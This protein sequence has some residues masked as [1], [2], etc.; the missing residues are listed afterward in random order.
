MSRMKKP[1]HADAL[2]A[3][4]QTLR[5]NAERWARMG[6][7]Q[8]IGYLE[9]C[10]AGTVKVAE[11]QIRAAAAAKGLPLDSPLVGEEWFAGPVVQARTLRLLLD[12]L[13]SVAA[14]GTVKLPK[15]STHPHNGQTVVQVFPTSTIDKLTFAGFTA[16]VWMAPGV[17]PDD[18]RDH[19]AAFYREPDPKPAVA[20]VLGAGNV[21]SIGPLDVIQKLFQ[22]GQVVMLKF[23][24]V[25]DYLGPFVE[26]AFAG[27]IRDGFLRTCYGGADVGAYL[28]DHAEV[29]EIHVTGS[30]KT[31]DVIVFGPGKAGE[32]R[33]KAGTPKNPRRVTSELGNVSPVIIVPGPWN[34]ADI[35]FHA[36]NV[37]TQLA[38]NGG[39]NCNAAKV[40]ITQEGWPLEQRFMDTLREVLAGIPQ[41]KAYYP[42][43]EDRY[44]AFVGAH[45]QSE[46]IGP[47]REGVLP[48]TLI[49]E[50][51]ADAEGEMC[52][53]TEAFCGVLAQTRLP[54]VDAR[55]FLKA[56]V[57]FCNDTLWG[58]LNACLIVHPDTASALGADLE[59]AI[60][61]LRYGTVALNHWPALAYGLGSTPWGAWPG[62]TPEDIQSGVGHVHNGY[63]IDDPQKTII[64]GPFRV[65]PKPPWFV[66]NKAT[67]KV[68][69]AMLPMELKPSLLKL[70]KV[71]FAALRG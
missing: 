3:D 55:A 45:A 43:A 12:S 17:A 11:R 50:V 44:R 27:L 35:R 52:F 42:G 28:T 24:P 48:W 1:E 57:D 34:A 30:D 58:T 59:Q 51:P 37:A 22:E 54:G 71:V 29:D 7:Q 32:K 8:R 9:A 40:L 31:H 38:N 6:I 69:R 20:L 41:R 63:L 61:D 18:M 13:R 70:P 2:D 26:E 21:A 23:N 49:P 67:D 36:E 4:L 5:A 33:K 53:G 14:S 56:A 46:P 25:N 68:A 39:F 64:R 47:E 62:A 15:V 10:L 19:V 16:E 66:T 60:G 65:A